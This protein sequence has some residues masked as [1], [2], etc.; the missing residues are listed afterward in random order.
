MGGLFPIRNAANSLLS[1]IIL[2]LFVSIL[3]S[4]PPTSNSRANNGIWVNSTGDAVKNDNSCTLREAVIAAN[5]DQKSG[6]KPNECPAGN[7]ADIIYL[8]A[9]LGTFTLTRT[10]NGNEDSS[11]TGDLDITDDLSIEAVGK[12]VIIR[13]DSD[14]SDR[15]FHVI[16]GNVTFTGIAIRGGNVNSSGGAISNSGTLSLHNVTVFNNSSEEDGG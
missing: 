9:E 8:P 7:G 12:G 2:V 3:V 11:Q 15:I 16:S 14:F 5:R 13:G 10:D 4:I 1:L 6:Q